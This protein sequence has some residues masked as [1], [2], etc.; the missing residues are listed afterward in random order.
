LGTICASAVDFDEAVF[1]LTK[2]MKPYSPWDRLTAAGS[3]APRRFVS[4][5][6]IESGV[7]A[8]LCRR[9][10]DLHTFDA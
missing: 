7:A 6:R 4:D 8:A 2:S 3:E 5:C 1:R 9:T 10:Q